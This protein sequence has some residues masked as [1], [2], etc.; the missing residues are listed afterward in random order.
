AVFRQSAAYLW[1]LA[2]DQRIADL[3]HGEVYGLSF[4]PDSRTLA[5]AGW[6]SKVRFW[7]SGSGTLL[8]EP[9]VAEGRQNEGDLRMYT[10]CYARQGD[11]IATA[12]FDGAVRI[13]NASDLTF[14]LRFQVP[15][16]FTWG[17]MSF[18]PDGLWLATGG[19]G[20]VVLWDPRSG[21]ALWAVG[22]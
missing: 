1:D 10:V 14:K 15:G 11:L 3:K 22:Q 9:N 20:R 19:S 21:D 13:W 4:S 17:A 12:H 18:S 2:S 16:R 8:R 7:D 5:T 6:D